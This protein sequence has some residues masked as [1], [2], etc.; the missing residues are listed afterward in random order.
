MVLGGYVSVFR[1][2]ALGRCHAAVMRGRHRVQGGNGFGFCTTRPSMV[3]YIDLR[4]T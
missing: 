2:L 4:K 3:V 1:D